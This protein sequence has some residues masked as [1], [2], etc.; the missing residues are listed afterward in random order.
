MI[1]RVGVTVL[2]NR[3]PIPV[4]ERSGSLENS[5]GEDVA[6]GPTRVGAELRAARERLGWELPA[7]AAWLRIRLSYLEAL[8]AGHLGDLPAMAYAMGFLRTYAAALGLDPDEQA[9]RFKACAVEVTRKT[10][11]EFPAPVPDRGVPAG[12]AV[13]VALVLAIGAYVGWYRLSGEGRLPAEV[14]QPVPERLAPLAEQAIPLP[15]PRPAAE[16]PPPAVAAAKP[17]PL[18]EMPSVPPSSAAAMP[19]PP[20]A[21]PASPATNPDEPRIVLRARADAW[22]QV[23]DRGGQVLLNR[24]LRAGETWPVPVRANLLLTTGNAGGTEVLVD[25]VVAPALGGAGAVRRDLPLDADTIKDGKLAA[26]IQASSSAPSSGPAAP[27]VPAPTS[28]PVVRNPSS[29]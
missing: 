15:P 1:L 29:Q 27:G 7:V 10:E 3:R 4:K 5:P 17:E 16:P 2:Q 13:L 18:P 23:R 25:G 24:I 8:E 11:L 26:Q 9:R 14:V 12:A 6:S 28:A 20:V 19:M 22:L 21:P